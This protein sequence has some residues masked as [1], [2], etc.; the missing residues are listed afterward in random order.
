MLCY[1]RVYN[2]C[3]M[4]RIIVIFI[5]MIYECKCVRVGT[6]GAAFQINLDA[7]FRHNANAIR[8]GV[9]DAKHVTTSQH[10]HCARNSSW[11][12]LILTLWHVVDHHLF[13]P[14]YTHSVHA[15]NDAFCCHDT[16]QFC[17]MIILVIKFL[18]IAYK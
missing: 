3:H 6:R 12:P 16:A 4:M 17:S 15:T 18:S 9:S 11:W 14:I 8:T 10:S 2:K 7:I 1:S 5:A 13:L